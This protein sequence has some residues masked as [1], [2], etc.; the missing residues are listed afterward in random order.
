M[1]VTLRCD[2]DK[3]MIGPGSSMAW[4]VQVTR[5]NGF[6][7]PVKIDVREALR[8]VDGDERVYA[9]FRSNLVRPAALRRAVAQSRRADFGD[10]Q[11]LYLTRV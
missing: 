6:A 2:A 9:I 4:F 7:E 8:G 11:W 1:V 5:I 10:L 3:A